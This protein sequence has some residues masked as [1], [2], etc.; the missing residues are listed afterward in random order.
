MEI[1]F[2]A[3]VEMLKLFFVLVYL[4]KTLNQAQIPPKVTRGAVVSEE[5]YCGLQRQTG[6]ISHVADT[7]LSAGV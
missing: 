7:D 4:Q 3:F 5:Y 2:C 6:L 1:I